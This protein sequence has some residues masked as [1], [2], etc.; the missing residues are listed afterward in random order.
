MR[1]ISWLITTPIA[2]AAILFALSNKH[3]VPLY[4]FIQEI[5][6]QIPLYLIALLPFVFG[7]VFGGVMSW[8]SQ[9]KH[10]R[11]VRQLEKEIKALEKLKTQKFKEDAQEVSELDDKP[12]LRLIEQK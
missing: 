2:L 6:F 3:V 4:A 9:G 8:W 1:L 7:F 12:D 11:K 5:E 10:R